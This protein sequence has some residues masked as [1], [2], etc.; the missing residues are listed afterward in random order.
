MIILCFTHPKRKKRMD[1]KITNN[2]NVSISASINVF[3]T[4]GWYIFFFFYR[5]LAE[6]F[7]HWNRIHLLVL[8]LQI[9]SHRTT[10]FEKNRSRSYACIGNER[11][12]PVDLFRQH[13]LICYCNCRDLTNSKTPHIC[14]AGKS[15]FTSGPR[16]SRP[17]VC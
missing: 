16:D 6:M 10:I 3:V 7:S 13:D 14:L 17:F 8:F 4:T 1:M 9:L 12:M 15:K 2:K 11:I 5:S